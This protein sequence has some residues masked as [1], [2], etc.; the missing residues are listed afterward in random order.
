[1]RSSAACI[2]HTL[3]MVNQCLITKWYGKLGPIVQK[4]YKCRGG[5][6]TGAVRVRGGRA[7]VRACVRA[8]VCACGHVRM[9]ACGRADVCGGFGA[10]KQHQGESIVSNLP[11]KLVV[12]A[13]KGVEEPLKRSYTSCTSARGSPRNM[14]GLSCGYLTLRSVV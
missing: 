10:G 13:K 5:R 12:V 7:G 2:G 4:K 1:M 9:C 14:F 11:P 8:G 6:G 3:A